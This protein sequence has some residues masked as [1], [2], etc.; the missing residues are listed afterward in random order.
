MQRMRHDNL[1]IVGLRAPL[2]A[3]KNGWDHQFENAP[4]DYSKNELKKNSISIF[5]TFIF[6]FI[7]LE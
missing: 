4:S 5:T 7:F 1:E 3:R 2:V 6:Y